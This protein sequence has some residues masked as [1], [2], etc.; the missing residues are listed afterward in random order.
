MFF[1]LHYSANNSSMLEYVTLLF[2]STPS[3]LFASWTLEL[4]WNLD[5]GNYNLHS[6]AA[7]LT[8]SGD[9][10]TLP[11]SASLPAW[12]PGICVLELIL[13]SEN[14]AQR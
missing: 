3:L 5:L 10:W 14:C 12:W 7:V 9:L 1:M 6:K 2:F 4:P 13:P 8:C 11:H